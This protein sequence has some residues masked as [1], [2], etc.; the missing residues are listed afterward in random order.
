MGDCVLQLRVAEA[1]KQSLPRAR[2]TWLGRDSWTAIV[3]RCP[4]VDEAV[5][6]DAIGAHRLF[7]PGEEVDADL[8]EFLHRFDLIANGATGPGEPATKRLQRAAGAATVCYPLHP[9]ARCRGHVCR[10][11]LDRI[12]EQL[13]APAADL[14]KSLE[15][16]AATLPERGGVLLAARHE[17]LADAARV[18]QEAGCGES[19]GD[20]RILL[21]QP[22]SGGMA[23]CWPIGNFSR[24]AE[25]LAEQ[26]YAPVWLFGPAEVERLGAQID[27]VRRRWPA[28]VDPP[29][30]VLIGL[31]A[32][33]AGYVGND[34][35]PTHLAAAIGTATIAIFGPT[36]PQL[37]GP[38]GP[39]VSVLRSHLYGQSWQ[40][41]PAE[42]VARSVSIVLGAAE[43]GNRSS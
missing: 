33:A 8:G 28:V 24:L 43:R 10:Q 16:H 42:S 17:D 18:L 7:G 23:K 36:E 11:W 30:A 20:Q 6:M 14:A 1:F 21:I 9:E 5:G 29:L 13:D 37:W 22:G 26:G 41:V 19:T 27:A 35:G 12:A 4:Y 38:L 34:A 31:L 40:D 39:K 32:L 2:V 15:C 3:K 25:I